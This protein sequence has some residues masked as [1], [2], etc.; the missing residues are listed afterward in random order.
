MSACIDTIQPRDGCVAGLFEVLEILVHMFRDPI[1]IISAS[2]NSFINSGKVPG[3]FLG[4][5]SIET[6]LVRCEHIR[7]GQLCAREDAYPTLTQVPPALPLS[8]ISV[9]APYH[10]A[11]LRPL[12][13]PPL[14]PPMTI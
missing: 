2:I 6:F 1:A 8:M 3:H 14:P 5:T 9:F 12:P 11:A 4:D 10:A 13:L 7:R